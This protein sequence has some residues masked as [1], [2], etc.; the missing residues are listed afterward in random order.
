MNRQF[1]WALLCALCVLVVI[2]LAVQSILSVGKYM[3][4]L[5]CMANDTQRH[6]LPPILAWAGLKKHLIY[7]PLFRNR[8]IQELQLSA[9]P[10]MCCIPTRPQ[11]CIITIIALMNGCFCLTRIPWKSPTEDL[12]PVIRNRLGTIAVVNLIP[13]ILLPG[14]HNHLSRLLS[15]KFD[16]LNLIHRWIGRIIMLEAVTHAA[17]WIAGDSERFGWSAVLTSVDHSE[18]IYTGL[19]ACLA[20]MV[21]SLHSL[22]MIRHAFYETFLHVHVLLVCLAI[23]GLW[24][25]LKELYARRYLLAAMGV[26]TTQLGKRLIRYSVLFW[27]NCGRAITRTTVRMLPGE[28]LMVTIS[29][30]RPWT[31]LPGQNI[32]FYIPSVGLWTSHPFTVAWH[33]LEEVPDETKGLPV[34]WSDLCTTRQKTRIYLIIRRRTGFTNQLYKRIETSQSKCE[35]FTALV[36]GPYGRPCHLKSYGTVILFAGGVGITYQ[37][38]HV[39]HLIKDATDNFIACHQISLVWI[40]RRLDYIEWVQ[41]WLRSL[42]DL[43]GA[44]GIL[45]VRIFVTKLFFP[46]GIELLMGRPDIQW[47]NKVVAV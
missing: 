41:P 24:Y 39:R 14:R 1:S 28:A 3:R 7:A 10:S 44:R 17:M 6:Y 34:S 4:L 25:H 21:L 43:P 9:F 38:L 33:E 36:E 42:F 40:I 23:A 18:F 31:I 37:L 12:Y 20:F 16:N 46:E 2:L 15:I 27:R 8:H 30:A 11:F 45:R 32:F 13:L 5:G 22:S 29:V 19:I 47:E 35:S 26:W